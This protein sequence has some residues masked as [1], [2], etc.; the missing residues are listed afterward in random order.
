MPKQPLT[1]ILLH[2]FFITCINPVV[3]ASTIRSTSGNIDF[4]SNNDTSSEMTLSSSGLG[5]G[6]SSPSAN[7]HVS[8]NGIVSNDLIIGTTVNTSHST[9]HI[10]GTIGYSMQSVATGSNTINSS[11][12][13]ADTSTG[14]I[15]L[16]LPAP[17]NTVGSMIT[18]KR[19]STSNDLHLSAGGGNIEGSGSSVFI[20]AG[21][22]A[23]FT[24]I[25]TGSGW[26]ILNSSET[27]DTSAEL[28][29]SNVFLWWK[30]NES[31]GSVATDGSSS[32]RGGNL[33]NNHSFS[34]NSYTATPLSPGL[35]LDDW[36]DTVA[37][38]N[39]TFP[40]SGY[41]Y[42]LWSK[43]NFSSTDTITFE[44]EIAGPAGF[45]WASGNSFIHKS[46][47]HQL[48]DN[49]YVTTQL[50]STLSA[51]TW[52]HVAVTWNG[53]TVS[54][55]LDGSLES[56]N[57]AGSWT[58]NAVSSSNVELTNPG[59]S[60]NDVYYTDDLRVYDYALTPDEVLILYGTGNP[61][62]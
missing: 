37:S 23:Y 19:V 51:N 25:N 27:I 35:N 12:V 41:T 59:L 6:V 33:S 58:G 38:G 49:S 29:S 26:T 53:S 18:I 45:V 62:P 8:G 3:L 16:V 20:G 54:L 39:V 10:N 36:D 28:A 7:L 17:D 21:N 44:P 30:L 4:D 47:Y 43:Y 56:G 24:L 40:N 60:E 5:I 46:A 48:A 42:A 55:Y 50:S 52:H 14:N 34:G 15:F 11:I 13:I 32:G 22:L 57:S 1:L 2:L 9:L 61:S 31:S